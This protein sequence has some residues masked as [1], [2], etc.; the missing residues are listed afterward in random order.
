ME[1]DCKNECKSSVGKKTIKLLCVVFAV[2][3]LLTFLEVISGFYANSAS[4]VG[5]GLHNTSDAF[6]ILISIIA[7]KIGEKK[8]DSDFTYGYKRTETIGSFINLILLFISGVY[9]LFDGIVKIYNPEILNGGL[10]IIISILSIIID[11]LTAKITHSHSHN[12]SNMKM[13]FLHNLSDLLGSVGVI[14]AGI[15]AIYFEWYFVDGI[16]AIMIALYMIISSVLNFGSIARILMNATPRH[17]ELDKIKSEILKIDGVKDAHHI[18]VW[19]IDENNISFE[20]HLVGNNFKI[21][22]KVKEVLRKF[23]IKHSIIQLESVKC[24]ESCCC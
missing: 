18:H 14:V 5:D 24:A 21:I 17:V 19:S 15:F 7:Y 20:C 23:N 8:A 4:L 16:I 11:S 22:D 12:N 6:S 1:C 2:N 10:I 3:M 13:L 9:L